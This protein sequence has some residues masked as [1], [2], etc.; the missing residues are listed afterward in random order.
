VKSLLLAASALALLASPDAASARRRPPPPLP[1]YVAPAV[2]PSDPVEAYYFT[3][4]SAPVWLR[5]PDSRVALA[6]LPALLRRA[7]AEGLANGAQ[8]AAD[9]EGKTAAAASG[10]PAAVLAAE[11]AASKAWVAYVQMLKTP[12]Q[13]LIYGYPAMAPQGSRAD[14]IMLTTA[15]APSLAQYVAKTVDPNPTYVALRNAAWS[16]LQASGSIDTRMLANLQ[17][18][19]V[20]PSGG[21]Y[22]LVNAATAQLTM[23]ENGQPVDGMKVVVG[24]TILPTPMIVSMIYYATLNPYWNVPDHLIRQ[25]V[26]PRYLKEGAAYLKRQGYEVMTDWSD[27]SAV[28]PND[29]VDWKGLAAGTAHVRIRQRPGPTNSM[30]KMKFNFRNSEDIYL[31]DSP[32]REYFLKPVR[33]L[34]NGCIRLEDARR[35]GRWLMQA[36]PVANGPT[37]EQHIKLPEGVPVY[38]TYLTA[39]PDPKTGQLTNVADVYSRDTGARVASGTP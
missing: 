27:N 16:A 3:H 18:A 23:F 4:G 17:R 34:S 12:P 7:Q 33:T 1:V 13:G 38:V 24:K 25:N 36:E 22:I 39:F 14:Q 19:R 35:L 11:T 26:A 20:L 21:K 8:L 31:H 10:S 28:I 9:I 37:P 5:S 30:G 2:V 15:A 29:Q 6:Q 32:E